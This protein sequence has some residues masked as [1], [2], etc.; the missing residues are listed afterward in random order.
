[1]SNEVDKS[2]SHFQE[3]HVVGNKAE[4]TDCGYTVASLDC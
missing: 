3:R 1:M 4:D 2:G